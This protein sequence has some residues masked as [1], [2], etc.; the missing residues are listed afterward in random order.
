MR[1]WTNTQET[2]VVTQAKEMRF[3]QTRWSWRSKVG[4]HVAEDVERGVAFKSYLKLKH[5]A[6]W[7]DVRIWEK[8][9][10]N[11]TPWTL[12]LQPCRGTGL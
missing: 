2:I 6:Q 3:V 7:L 4:T 11:K 9:V 8:E 1:G 5:S 10:L 12:N